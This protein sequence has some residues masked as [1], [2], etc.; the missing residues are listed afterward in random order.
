MPVTCVTKNVPQQ[1]PLVLAKL[2]GQRKEKNHLQNPLHTWTILQT[3]VFKFHQASENFTVTEIIFAMF[4]KKKKTP[5]KH[6]Y[7][8]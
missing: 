1:N 5:I 3:K 7:A 6:P 2:D 8:L 4:D